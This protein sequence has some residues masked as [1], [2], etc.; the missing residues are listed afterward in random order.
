[1]ALHCAVLSENQLNV[2]LLLTVMKNEQM[3]KSS[4]EKSDEATTKASQR[5]W[6]S[7]M[8]DC[9]GESPLHYSARLNHLPISL[10]LISFGFDLSQK[11][12]SECYPHDLCTDPDVRTVLYGIYCQID[13]FISSSIIN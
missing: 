7:E 10:L 13:I 4:G 8:V 9:S 5:A 12:A 1:M 6:L 2:D 3:K 11:S